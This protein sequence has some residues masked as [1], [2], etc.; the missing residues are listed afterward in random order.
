MQT[1]I[2]TLI[3]VFVDIMI[4]VGGYQMGHSKGCVDAY[5]KLLKHIQEQEEENGE[6]E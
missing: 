6:T 4:F 1:F 5:A 3:T 2:F